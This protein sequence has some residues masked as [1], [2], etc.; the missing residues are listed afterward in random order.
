MRQGRP[1]Q[2]GISKPS[3]RITAVELVPIKAQFES[4]TRN[5]LLTPSYPRR[6]P[7]SCAGQTWPA[8]STPPGGF[9][10]HAIPSLPLILSA[11]SDPV[12]KDTVQR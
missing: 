9:P 8:R 2:I 7:R 1:Q 11:N 3:I 10:P 5:F 6:P 4:G 12:Q